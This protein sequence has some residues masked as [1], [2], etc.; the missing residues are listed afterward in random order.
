MPWHK[1]FVATP[2]SFRLKLSC[3]HFFNTGWKGSHGSTGPRTTRMTRTKWTRWYL[4]QR[5]SQL[6]LNGASAGA[7]CMPSCFHCT[8]S[9][10]SCWVQRKRDT[11]MRS[12]GSCRSW[13]WMELS[14]RRCRVILIGGAL[15][16]DRCPF[17]RLTVCI[18]MICLYIYIYN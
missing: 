1:F 12:W 13:W 2:G 5:F 16:Q 3:S 8:M 6:Q 18:Y 17:C 7:I 11:K 9:E 10:W 4:R 14:Q 15:L